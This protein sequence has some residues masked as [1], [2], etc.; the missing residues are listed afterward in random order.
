VTYLVHD[1]QPDAQTVQSIKL[2]FCVSRI[3]QYAVKTSANLVSGTLLQ[4]HTRT[5]AA[6]NHE[7]RPTDAILS[8]KVLV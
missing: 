8:S 1:I 3:E 2:H 6:T 5:Y 7:Y 4:I